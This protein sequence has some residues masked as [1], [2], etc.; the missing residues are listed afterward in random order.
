MSNQQLLEELTLII[1][2]MAELIRRMQTDMNMMG[3]H[4]YDAEILQ[5]SDYWEE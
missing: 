5:L 3:I 2:E 1:Q 4:D